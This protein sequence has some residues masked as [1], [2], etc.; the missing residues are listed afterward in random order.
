MGYNQKWYD[1]L[2]Q[3]GPG[4]NYVNTTGKP[5]AVNISYSGV[6]SFRVVVGGTVVKDTG[7]YPN[8]PSL[9]G[10]VTFI[11]PVG[12]VYW[13]STNLGET[14]DGKIIVWAELR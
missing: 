3:R 4:I 6:Y 8:T 5:I 9:M 7:R 14:P 1:V 13:V 11:V 12:D 2:S 10:E